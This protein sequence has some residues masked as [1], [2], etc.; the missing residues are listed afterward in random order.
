M[1]KK[2]FHTTFHLNT[3]NIS[4]MIHAVWQV[5]GH[6]LSS[7]L[8][9]RASCKE[10]KKMGRKEGNLNHVMQHKPEGAA[11]ITLHGSVQHCLCSGSYVR[12][13]RTDEHVTVNEMR[14]AAVG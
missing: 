9:L 3:F 13:F 10:L 1:T 4:G 7:L 5:Y 14:D 11:G 8:I 2:I 6:W 12:E